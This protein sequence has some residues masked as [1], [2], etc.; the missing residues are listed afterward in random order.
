MKKTFY[1]TFI[2]FGF[3]LT[4]SLDS[5][6]YNLVKKEAFAGHTCCPEDGSTCPAG[7]STLTDYYKK[8][9]GSCNSDGDSD[10]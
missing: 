4:F 2:L 6:D 3:G 5:E 7:S 9:E 10:Y 8:S 1:Y